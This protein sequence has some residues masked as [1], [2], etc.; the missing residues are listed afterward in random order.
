M[1]RKEIWA[2]AVFVASVVD[3]A[4]KGTKVKDRSCKVKLPVNEVCS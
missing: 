4:L 2:L 1:F 3:G